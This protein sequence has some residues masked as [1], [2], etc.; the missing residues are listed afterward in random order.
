MDMDDE[1]LLAALSACE[2]AVWQA[3][4]DGDMAADALALADGFVGIYSS[5]FAGKADHVGQLTDGPTVAR[6]I[7]SEMQVMP[8]GHDHAVLYYSARFQRPAVDGW[9]QMYVSSV[10]CRDG[11]GWV[12][13]LSQDT[14][15]SP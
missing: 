14:P 6:F 4:V 15:A 9:E 2:H 3:L 11:D 12:N 10:W 1:T 13:M 8:L 5:G 7:L